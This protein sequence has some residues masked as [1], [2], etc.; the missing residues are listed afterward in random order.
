MLGYFRI[1]FEIVLKM[2]KGKKCFAINTKFKISLN[3]FKLKVNKWA[4]N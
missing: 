2:F 3:H 1:S 4:R